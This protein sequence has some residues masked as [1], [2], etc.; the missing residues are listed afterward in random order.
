MASRSRRPSF[1]GAPHQYHRAARRLGA[2]RPIPQVARVLRC[3]A[4]NL[5]LLLREE[6]FAQLFRAHDDL[7]SLAPEAR[8]ARLEEVA[9]LVLEETLEAKDPRVA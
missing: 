2:G 8:V 7:R 1:T 3:D 6:P 9:L 5:H 4:M